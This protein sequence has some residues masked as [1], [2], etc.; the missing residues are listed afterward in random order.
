MPPFKFTFLATFGVFLFLIAP[1]AFAQDPSAFEQ[2]KQEYQDCIAES[3]ADPEIAHTNAM[4]WRDTGGGLPAQH[5]VALSLASLGRYAEA[6]VELE[7][8]ASDLAHG[9]GWPFADEGL[10]LDRDLLAEIYAQAGNAWLLAE[11]PNKA[12]E[13]FTLAMAEVD[14]LSDT[15]AELLIDRATSQAGTGEYQEALNDLNLAENMLGENAWLHA[16]KASAYRGLEQYSDAN[17]EL[18]YAFSLEPQNREA[19]LERGN[20]RREVGDKNGARADW[21]EYLRLYPDSVTAAAVR[22]NIEVMD[23]NVEEFNPEPVAGEEED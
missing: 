1:S 10:S 2:E 5:C 16:L 3:E 15:F 11:F 20:L 17:S 21:L 6:A 8:M 4:T 9:I 23:V 12:T 18:E 14:P 22:R 13:V 7:I 19:L